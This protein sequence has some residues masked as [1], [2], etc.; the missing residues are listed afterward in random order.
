MSSESQPVV[1][2]VHGPRIVT[3]TDSSPDALAVL[4]GRIIATG[5]LDDLLARFPEAET[6][7]LDGALLIPGFNDAHLHPF[8]AAEPL[9]RIDLGPE[10]APTSESALDILRHRAAI[11]EPGRWIVGAGLDVVHGDVA[12]L[13]RRALD[14]VS[15]QHP[16]YIIGSTWHT[17]VAN[18]VALDELL[19]D[20]D[21]DSYAG[22]VFSRDPGGSLNGWLHESPHMRVV[23]AGSEQRPLLPSLPVPVLVDALE[24]QNA[25]LHSNGITSY[26]D[27]LVTPQMWAAYDHAHREGRLTARVSMALWHTYRDR[28]TALGMSSD[29]GNEWLRF[30]GVKF[31]YDGAI[32]GGTC[33]C[34][35][36]YASVSGTGNGI[37]VLDLDDL[38]EAVV[39]L[40]AQGIRVCIHANGD[41]AITD[42]LQAIETA[43]QTTPSMSINHRIEH[44]SM[45]DDTLLARLVEAEVTAV[46]FGGFIRYHGDALVRMYGRDRAAQLSRHRT[47]MHAGVGVAGSSDYP[48][49]PASVLTALYSMVTRQ[50]ESGT[51]IGD[52]ERVGIEDALRIYTV[53]SAAATGEDVVKGRLAPGYLA[54]FTVLSRDILT[55][56]PA[57]LLET[58]VLSTWVGGR[59][60]WNTDGSHPRDTAD[61]RHRPKTRRKQIRATAT[62]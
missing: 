48:C 28:I 50:S 19:A 17:A 47:L 62:Y 46:P 56:E 7:R 33:L 32:S 31:M 44:C 6:I 25:F 55:A 43:R 60:V 61:P 13:D 15:T 29:Y 21:P 2:I 9:L 8:F 14:A 40:H 5:G 11:T 35:R 53:G 10:S 27:A 24:E 30:A 12:G 52:S 41:A 23:W 37:R 38:T 57:E 34:S 51:I 54:D 22:G 4:A 16:I 39:D 36:P 59:C 42:V 3:L 18:S 58:K 45:V 26:T 49:G 1:Q 20:S